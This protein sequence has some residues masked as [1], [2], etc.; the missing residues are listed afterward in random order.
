MVE[1]LVENTLLM[2]N[3]KTLGYM[4]VKRHR[5]AAIACRRMGAS[6]TGRYLLEQE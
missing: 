6:K 3:Q 2:D 1:R 5:G 4:G